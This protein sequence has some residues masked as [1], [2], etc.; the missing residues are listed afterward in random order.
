MQQG[1]MPN[2]TLY[3][4]F[5]KDGYR[6]N[7]TRI[8]YNFNKREEDKKY[9]RWNTYYAD[10][11]RA[12]IFYDTFNRVVRYYEGVSLG[13]IYYEIGSMPPKIK[14][15]ASESH[16]S[17]EGSATTI[18]IHSGAVIELAEPSHFYCEELAFDRHWDWE[19]SHSHSNRLALASEK[20]IQI[21]KKKEWRPSIGYRSFTSHNTWDSTIYKFGLINGFG[22][23]VFR[24][25]HSSPNDGDTLFT[26]RFVRNGDSCSNLVLVNGSWIYGSNYSNINNRQGE[27]IRY[28]QKKKCNQIYDDTI[29][30]KK[31]LE[32]INIR[33]A[34]LAKCGLVDSLLLGYRN[35]THWGIP[36]FEFDGCGNWIKWRLFDRR[37]G[38]LLVQETRDIK[39]YAD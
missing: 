30:L 5:N 18:Y 28:F 36:K 16:S 7:V 6:T 20:T 23:C 32:Q 1:G 39:Y 11:E 37:N 9:G 13:L 27:D 17:N 31:R 35:D 4:E 33:N 10:T 2:K 15:I 26:E 8:K 14:F 29:W 3:E 24:E 12:E 25:K 21:T 34:E 38:N 19:S 22:R